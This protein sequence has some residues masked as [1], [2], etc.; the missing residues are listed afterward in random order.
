MGDRYRK[1]T[2]YVLNSINKREERRLLLNME[3]RMI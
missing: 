2:L 3:N 1:K